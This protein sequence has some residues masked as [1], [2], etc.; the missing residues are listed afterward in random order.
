MINLRKAHLTAYIY[1]G[2]FF[3]GDFILLNAQQ[4]ITVKSI[5][6]SFI[7]GKVGPDEAKQEALVDA[8]LNA[9]RNAGI[10]EHLSSYQLLFTSQNNKEYSQFFNANIQL[11][12]EGAIKSYTIISEHTKPEG[13]S[14]FKI[15]IEIEAIVIKYS[16]IK[17]I[18]FDVNLS[19]FKAVYE[20]DQKLE[21]D[22]KLTQSCFMTIFNLIDDKECLVLYPL[23]KNKKIKLD[24]NK[25]IH[26]PSN[27][28]KE[29]DFVLYTSKKQESNQLIF[30]FTK[31]D[32]SYIRYNQD[33]MTSQEDMF[34]WIY[35]MSPD[36]RLVAYQS[37]FIIPSN[38]SK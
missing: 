38:K 11:E 3:L 35:S 19:G 13:G 31:E 26:F 8:K 1:F 32:I 34:N 36:Q 25:T 4:L 37:F 22:L 7:S 24:A 14:S 9:L 12:L 10:K 33:G 2:F 15:E 18:G 5:G 16:T 6:I 30:V 27:F 20:V 23:T 28:T 17:D 21:F 29:D